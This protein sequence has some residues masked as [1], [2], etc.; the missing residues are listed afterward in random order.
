[1]ENNWI[2]W[3]VKQIHTQI[4]SVKTLWR[5][6]YTWFQVSKNWQNYSESSS[7]AT[8]L[9]KNSVSDMKLAD[10]WQLRLVSGNII[11]KNKIKNNSVWWF[12]KYFNQDF[13]S[14]NLC[15]YRWFWPT[16]LTRLHVCEESGTPKSIQLPLQALT[17]DD[18]LPHLIYILNIHVQS[19]WEN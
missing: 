15:I 7:L 10:N 16:E 11:R 6:T 19:R 4:H 3:P 1:M 8:G 13:N 14:T 9:R 2:S 18:M 17:T 12:D 5:G